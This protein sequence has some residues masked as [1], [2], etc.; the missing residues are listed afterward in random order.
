MKYNWNYFGGFV[1]L[2]IIFATVISDHGAPYT[3]S[4]IGVVCL[5]ITIIWGIGFYT[6]LGFR[7]KD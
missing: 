3:W 4:E 1:A 6:A 5:G 7:K 2:L